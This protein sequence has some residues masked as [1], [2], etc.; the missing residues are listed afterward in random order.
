MQGFHGSSPARRPNC[1]ML[2]FHMLQIS[3]K[4]STSDTIKR[5]GRASLWPMAF[6][7]LACALFYEAFTEGALLA[8]NGDGI[9]FFYPLD[10]FLHRALNSGHLPM[11]NPY[12]FSGMPFM[13]AHQPAVLY[14]PKLALFLL[15]PAKSAFN[16]NFILH[17]AMGGYFA[18]LYFR[19][20]SGSTLPALTGALL[21]AYIGYL[22]VA[23][24][25]I[26]VI[27]ASAWM[28]LMLLL[29]E[30]ITGERPVRSAAWLSVAVGLQLLAGH[31]QTTMYTHMLVLMAFAF[32]VRRLRGRPLAAALG[33]YIAAILAGMLLAL[34]QL[35][36]TAELSSHAWRGG[37]GYEFFSSL[38]FRPSHMPEMVFPWLDRRPDLGFMGS[39]PLLLGLSS[40]FMLARRDPRARL[41]AVVAAVF[42]ILSLG[43]QTPLYRLMYHV[44]GYN[45]F[46]APER[47]MFEVSFALIALCT[48]GLKDIMQEGRRGYAM[49][50]AV[51]TALAL[52]IPMTTGDSAKYATGA[53]LVP[54]AFMTAYTT[55]AAMGVLV[56][57]LRGRRAFGVALLIVL[58]AEIFTYRPPVAL[59]DK[60]SRLALGTNPSTMMNMASR[61]RLGRFAFMGTFSGPEYLNVGMSAPVIYGV[62]MLDGYEQLMPLQYY[63]LLGILPDSKF[64]DDSLERLLRNHRLLSMLGVRHMTIC[65]NARDSA[66]PAFMPIMTFYNNCTLYY[67]RSA[68]PRAFAVT[69]A[70]Q[71]TGPAEVRRMT[72][73][74]S[75]EP[76]RTAALAQTDIDR[77]GTA[78][79]APGMVAVTRYSSDKVT[80]SAK[81][82]GDGLVVL[83]DQYFPGWRAYVDGSEVP[84]MR[85]NGVLRAV[86]VP[87]GE[88]TVIMRYAPGYLP[89]ALLIS[90]ATILA[91]AGAML[92]E[93]KRHKG[94][95]P[96]NRPAA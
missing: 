13:A 61:D 33:Y 35:M 73:D 81:M 80:L 29:A 27:L 7:A 18:F 53:V 77:L 5:M 82:E 42:F 38:P 79:F 75:L 25:H 14:P 63:D 67:N 72:M 51:L 95:S 9:N 23:P 2:V 1:N 28:P 91:V 96:P 19:K 88:H 74:G 37:L 84:L 17:Y 20:H 54:L 83:A 12:I 92:L 10:V 93:L 71:S 55:W 89:P 3:Q 50:M 87:A 48:M 8:S 21:F 58:L 70:V 41:W 85:A 36:A 45:L 57:A 69:G 65:G 16:M 15:L 31:A 24:D 59:W 68:L 11:W 44:P 60:I 30:G 49:L 78:S 66:A 39:M 52:I 6:M 4:S 62:Q 47:H 32:S 64:R 43:D 94:Q 86:A 76:A 46:R 34:P 56:P 22:H 90:M 26:P 40:L